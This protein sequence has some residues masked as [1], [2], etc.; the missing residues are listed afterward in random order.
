MVRLPLRVR[1]QGL[2]PRALYRGLLPKK[3]DQHL[4]LKGLSDLTKRRFGP[5]SAVWPRYRAKDSF[6]REEDACKELRSHRT[7]ATYTNL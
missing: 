6:L 2:L 7:Y 3:A 5:M 4:A 1:Q